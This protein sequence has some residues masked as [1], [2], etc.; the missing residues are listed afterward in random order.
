MRGP[1]RLG[2]V[3]LSSCSLENVKL[4]RYHTK[5]LPQSRKNRP[6]NWPFTSCRNLVPSFPENINLNMIPILWIVKNSDTCELYQLS[7]SLLAFRFQGKRIGGK[8]FQ[9]H[10]KSSVF[11]WHRS[12][13]GPGPI[14]KC[15][16][17]P[18]S[19]AIYSGSWEE[20]VLLY[21]FYLKKKGDL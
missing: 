19:T 17:S 16:F 6:K 1:V 4:S 20:V 9:K 2:I 18:K 13:P 8:K 7:R 12:G 5:R 11:V 15:V 14:W 3:Y 21:S 10:F